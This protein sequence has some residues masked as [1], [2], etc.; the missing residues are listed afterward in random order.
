M[1]RKI[2]LETVCS[3]IETQA[4][5]RN[6]DACAETCD[7]Y[8]KNPVIRVIRSGVDN[9]DLPREDLEN[10]VQ[11]AILKEI[12]PMERFLSTMGMLAA[13]SPLLGLL[14]TVTGMIDTFHVITM[15]GTGD[16]RMM[17]GGISEALVTTMLGLSVAIPIMLSHTLLSRAVENCVEMMEEKATTLINIV[18]KFKVA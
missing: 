12:P 10:A 2:K 18:Q 16:P 7:Q 5:A 17:S 11:E 3:I 9:R 8:N 14:G 1:R 15:H 13:I 6:W 4:E